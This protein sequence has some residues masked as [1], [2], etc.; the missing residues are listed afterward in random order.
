MEALQSCLALLKRSES[1]VADEAQTRKSTY[2]ITPSL[3]RS[4]GANRIQSRI[5]DPDTP[6][7]LHSCQHIAPTFCAGVLTN[8]ELDSFC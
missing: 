4:G 5:T 8:F 6:A 1:R 3:G 7:T 2:A